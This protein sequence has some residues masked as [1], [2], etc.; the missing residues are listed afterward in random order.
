MKPQSFERCC[1]TRSTSADREAE[2]GISTRGDWQP[3]VDEE[4]F[5]RVQASLN[6]TRP[7]HT[8]RHRDH[9]DFPLRRI[10]RCGH[11]G[12]PLAASHSKGRSKR[13]G[14]YRCR[15]ED[16]L[17]VK[18][19]KE[20]LEGEFVEL[21]A[22]VQPKPRYLKLLRAIILDSWKQQQAEAERLSRNLDQRIE[23]LKV[24]KDRLVD[25]FVHRQVLDEETYR[26]QVSRIDRDI[27]VARL[28]RHEADLEALDV[29]GVVAFAE[30]VLGDLARLWQELGPQQ[31]LKL[32]GVVFPEG[33]TYD[34]ES[35]GTAVT[36]P[37]FSYLR[38]IST[39]KEGVASPTGFEPDR[40]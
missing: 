32:Q 18:L 13:Y 4:T 5:D 28:E 8:R 34:G 10:V 36:S 12:T 2:W 40:A 23:D 22:K 9:P 25:A 11:C 39:Q 24:C 19:R 16:C 30:R 31:R 17:K 29:E 14:N 21:L 20:T 6:G 15:N 33:L 27:T 38:E 37:V 7:K 35:F 1:G 26:E 3:L